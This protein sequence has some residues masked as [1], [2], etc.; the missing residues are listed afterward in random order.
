MGERD[1]WR[2]LAPGVR[3]A[4]EYV[5]IQGRMVSFVIRLEKIQED[6]KWRLTAR[7]DTCHGVPHLDVVDKKG[8]LIFKKWMP[9][10]T[11]EQAFARALLDFEQNHEKFN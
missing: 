10:L 8:N 7:Y 1:Y 6:G 2:L 9:G 5:T 11:H 3:L 4:V